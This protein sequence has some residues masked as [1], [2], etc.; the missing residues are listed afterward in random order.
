MPRIF[1]D[2]WPQ[3]IEA[4]RLRI[5]EAAL[6][7]GVPFP[8]GCGSGEC[9]TCKCRLLE[10]EVKRDRNSP[11]ALS[12]EEVE[13]GLILAC[14]SRPLTDVM[15]QWLS[16]TAPAVMVKHDA[17][18]GRIE[19][20]SHDVV[21]LTVQLRDDQTFPFRAGQFAKLRF[22]RLPARSYSMA[23]QPG[24][25]DLVFH[26]R[27]HPQGR[28]GQHVADELRP[29]DPVEVRGPFGEAYWQGSAQHSPR[30][31][32]AGR[33]VASRAAAHLLLLAGG[34]GMAPILSVLDA[35]LRDG[36][37]PQSIDVYHGV[38]TPSDLYAGRDLQRRASEH[39]LRFVPVYAEG[40]PGRTGL[41][42][43]AIERDF[44]DLGASVI[45]VAGPPPMVDAVRGVAQKRG[46][47]PERIR[48]DAFHPSDPER[49]SLWE[50]ITAW[51]SL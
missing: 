34:T 24:D 28:V 15:V 43:D 14:R 13:Q 32:Q 9:G 20:A 46:A 5:L 23:S 4:G 7:A 22:G 49:R 29:G 21:L 3:P 26:I 25:R 41:L 18:V 42:H 16:D 40:G 36:H 30:A 31:P 10:G 12:D 1:I 38:R 6:D 37:D 2:E 35:A 44:D 45:H 19:R 51:G 47:A 39:G 17:V 8:H 11:D 50:R 33:A 27:V 48:A